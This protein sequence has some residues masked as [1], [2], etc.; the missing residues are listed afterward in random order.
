ML[1]RHPGHAE[2]VARITWC[3]DQHAIGVI[4]GEVGAGKTVAIRA[5]TAALDPARH[6][7]IYLPNP[8]VGV[9]ACCITSWARWGGCPASTPRP[10]HPR[11]PKRW[12]PSTPNAVAP[13]SW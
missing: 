11:P 9:R 7:I 12:L 10:W 13:R 4:T 6:V 2:A 3:V 5:A 8:S 1:H